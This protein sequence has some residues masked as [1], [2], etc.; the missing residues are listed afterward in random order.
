MELYLIR[1][2]RPDVP[3]GVCYGQSDVGLAETF[4]EELLALERKLPPSD[5]LQFFSSPLRRCLV[6]AEALSTGPVETDTR[7]MEMDFGAFEMQPWS[8][9]EP[10]ALNHWMEDFVNRHCPGGESYLDL[11]DRTVACFEKIIEKDHERIGLVVHGGVVRAL[12]SHVLELPLNR[13]FRLE[14][15]FGG[16]TRLTRGKHGFQV[17]YVNR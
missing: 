6:L 10:G 8:S 12:L 17:D 7:L 5:T 1:H 15:D 9:I 2:T 4:P 13:S 11:Y 14:I 16:V 3:E